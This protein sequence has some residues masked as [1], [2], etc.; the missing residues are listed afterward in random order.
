MIKYVSEYD[1]K[2]FKDIKALRRDKGQ[3]GKIKYADLVTAFDI[4]TT[5]IDEIENSV[6][7][8]WQFQVGL[9]TTVI[10]REWSEFQD[11]IK[12]IES[13]LD[14]M[15]LVTFVHNLSFEF[16]F[17]KSILDFKSIFAMDDRKVLKACTDAIEFRCSYLHSNM[18]LDK[19]LKTM[20][21]E[22]K[23]VK[24]FDYSKKRYAWTRLTDDEINYCVNDVKGL[25]EAVIKEMDKDGD[26]L[27]SY[28]L[29]STGYVRRE[30][31][32]ELKPY[33]LT[34]RDILPNRRVL[35][36]LRMAFRGGNT[37]A[38]RWNSNR[39][40]DDVTSYDI[41]SSYPSVMLTEKFPY[42]FVKKDVSKLE[43][44][45]N[46]GRACL[47]HIY[48]SNVKLIDDA[49]GCPYLAKGKC[50]NVIDGEFDNGR[51]LS[52][53]SCDVWITEIDFSILLSEYTF[54]YYIDELY[55]AIKKRLPKEFRDLLF[56]MYVNKT[57]LK[58]VDDYLYGKYKNK[59]NSVYGMTVQNP[60]KPI[61]ILK[62]G[63][64]QI[65]ES[66]TIDDL[67]KDYL[68]NGWLPYQWGVWVT[69]YARLKLE[70]GLH[71][72]PY[73]AF[74]YA[75]TDS[76]KFVGDYGKRIEELNKEYK[77]NKFSAVDK[78]GE[79]HYLG[80]F[81]KD[82]HYKKF[83]TLGAKKYC[84]L[85]DNDCLHVTVSGV[86]KKKG[87]EELKKIENFKEGF[88]FH[89]AGGTLSIYNDKPTI[90]QY[91]IRSHT[92]DITSN[93]AI[94]DSTYT[95][96]LTDEYRNLVNYLARNDIRYILQLDE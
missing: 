55:S 72:I 44:C 10:G 71:A 57:Q 22:D 74:I 76:I 1:Y 7:Y 35:Y 21:V 91:Y 6:M 56:S 34:I 59:V 8:I 38:N 32:K 45:L 70:R 73:D 88:T 39:I 79:V 94:Y 9:H 50:F 53:T 67:I 51:I 90:K 86:N 47:M 2:E 15:Y 17:L 81:E 96:G 64:L 80:I 61:Y 77:D 68:K 46:H 42:K 49:F 25:V 14:G 87:A 4:E 54:D 69:A 31:R 92:I 13:Y 84:Y 48:L 82:D 30:F 41:S 43:Q 11:F 27:Y 19:F 75:D 78:H 66:K 40:V 89:K 28:P 29:T 83:K 5:N 65:D 3:K 36:G 37:H 33:A 60:I 12:N 16:Q 63:I 26:N 20:D 23:K 85:D 95:L 93:V 24:G 52:C 58:G 18:S 62:D